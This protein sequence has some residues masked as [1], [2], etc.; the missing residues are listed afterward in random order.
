MPPD[1]RAARA[2]RCAAAWTVAALLASAACESSAGGPDAAATGT[3]APGGFATAE[4]CARCHSR[5]PTANALTTAL[6]DDGSPH[7]LWQATPMA[8]A[9]RD[10]YFRAE[11]AREV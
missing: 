7:G 9:F 3:P 10:P 1:Q 5:S 6:G 2:P 8:Q 4:L 11:L